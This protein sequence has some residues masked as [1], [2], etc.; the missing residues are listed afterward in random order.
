MQKYFF[1]GYCILF[2]YDI[3]YNVIYEFRILGGTHVQ[4]EFIKTSEYK[5]LYD[6]VLLSIV[7]YYY[8]YIGMFFFVLTAI[9]CFIR[10]LPIEYSGY[11]ILIG[12]KRHTARC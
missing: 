3:I 12:C 2:F 7:K 11:I 8:Y 6:K 9:N 5:I 10:I 4:E 1:L